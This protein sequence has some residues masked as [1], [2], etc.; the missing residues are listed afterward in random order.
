M[1]N[2]GEI[3]SGKSSASEFI[4]RLLKDNEKGI[5]VMSRVIPSKPEEIELWRR[6]F[7]QAAR[8][9]EAQP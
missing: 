3:R 9:M 2:P 1:D 8:K 5:V 6:I 7:K 4:E